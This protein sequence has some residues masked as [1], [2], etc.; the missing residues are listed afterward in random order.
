MDLQTIMLLKGNI[1]KIGDKIR[2]NIIVECG[3]ECGAEF[4][5]DK[6]VHKSSNTKVPLYRFFINGKIITRNNHYNVTYKCINCDAI[7]CVALNN[8][9]RKIN[10]GIVNCRICKEYDDLKRENHSAFMRDRVGGAKLRE[11]KNMKMKMKNVSLLERLENDKV[12]FDNYDSDF[13]DN[14]FKRNMDLLEFEYIKSK[15]ISIQNKKFLM[16]DYSDFIYFPCVSI[17]NQTRFCPYLY[18]KSRNN[19]EKIVNIELK[20]DSCGFSFISKD[21][22]SHKNRIKAL[23]KDCNLCNNVFKIRSYQN[24]A[25]ENICYQSKFELKFIRYCNEN[26]IYLINGPK[27]VYNS[28][29]KNRACTYRVDFAIPKLKLLVEIKDN[30]IWHRD[31]VESGRWDEK[32]QGVWDFIGAEIGRDKYDNFIVIFPKNYVKECDEIV[33]KYWS[34]GMRG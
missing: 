19:I 7:H 8:I 2:D 11:E 6:I 17:S 16:S 3:A 34:D 27:V 33:D 31:Q 14:Y 15:I 20:C 1:M 21:L 25:N 30:H 5:I 12:A 29:I 10:K 22:H 9:I 32:V 24:L 18:C 13:K 4:S 23:C 26:K 28:K